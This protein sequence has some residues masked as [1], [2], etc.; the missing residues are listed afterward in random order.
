MLLISGV[1]T[2]GSRGGGACPPPHFNFS[3]KQGPTVSVSNIRDI[4]FCTGVIE[5]LV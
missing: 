2:G 1:A 4:V 3:T 5:N